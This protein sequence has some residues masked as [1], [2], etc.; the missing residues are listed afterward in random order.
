MEPFS[1]EG[2]QTRTCRIDIFQYLFSHSLYGVRISLY[3]EALSYAPIDL[4]PIRTTPIS[5]A[6]WAFCCEW[7]RL[8]FFLGVISFHALLFIRWTTFRC[9]TQIV[10]IFGQMIGTI[11]VT[12]KPFRPYP[13]DLIVLPKAAFVLRIRALYSHN[14]FLSRLL[15][16]MLFSS[17]VTLVVLTVYMFVDI[18]RT[19]LAH[20]EQI[21]PSD[22]PLFSFNPIRAFSSRMCGRKKCIPW[23]DNHTSGQYRIISRDVPWPGTQIVVEL[24]VVAISA[25]H[26]FTNIRPYRVSG[27]AITTPIIY[28]LY[29]DGLLYFVVAFSLKLAT[30]LVVSSPTSSHR[31]LY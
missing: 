9:K 7:V 18:W 6:V 29:R 25:H 26:A 8:T 22:S 2:W 16:V 1:N 3:L 14:Q 10:V 23:L 11:V 21:F 5:N 12:S 30:I 4:N 24:V 27:T 20:T 31:P 13:I 17:H 19:C 28:V 15:L